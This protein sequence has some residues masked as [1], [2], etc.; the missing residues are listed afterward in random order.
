ML[1]FTVGFVAGVMLMAGLGLVLL[2]VPGAK[3]HRR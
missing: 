1:M 3:G 2:V